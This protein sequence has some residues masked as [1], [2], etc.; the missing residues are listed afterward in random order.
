VLPP[1]NSDGSSVYNRKGGSTVPVKFRVCDAAGRPIADPSV[2]FATSGS[3]TGI[4]LVSAVRGTVTVPNEAGINDI[5]DAVFRWTGQEWIF[6]MATSNLTSG[7][8]YKFQI[9]LLA[10]APITFQIGIK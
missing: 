8:T 2:V 5:P 4:M 6:N 3:S 1:I 10:G 9:N 7:T